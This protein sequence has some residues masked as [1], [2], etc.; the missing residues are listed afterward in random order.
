MNLFEKIV[1]TYI[2]PLKSLPSS[3]TLDRSGIVKSDH[4]K[5]GN[6]WIKG[7]VVDIQP[8]NIIIVCKHAIP[9]TSPPNNK[10][11]V[12]DADGV[13]HTRT[14]TAI[15]KESFLLNGKTVPREYYNGGDIA[16]CKVDEPFSDKVCGYKICTNPKV[17][18]RRALTLDQDGND[19]IAQVRYEEDF[20]Y[21]RGRKRWSNQLVGGD[22][23][24]PWFIYEKNEWRVLTHT[25]R[26]AYGEGPWYGHKYIYGEL[27]RRIDDLQKA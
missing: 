18:G 13:K 8:K 9:S 1:A 7:W 20:A 17:Y 3:K 6:G 16:I 14:I 21:I 26:G 22:S 23:G 24:M 11:Y 5:I 15:N 12:I 4:P 25:F 27:N 2:N 10:V 19:S